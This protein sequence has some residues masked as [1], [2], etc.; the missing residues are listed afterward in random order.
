[1]YSETHASSS[2]II[3][4]FVQFLLDKIK[5]VQQVPAKFQSIKFV[6]VQS[7]VLKLSQK[8]KD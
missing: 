5:I 1:M 2:D 6:K 4:T 3:I 8:K 7:E